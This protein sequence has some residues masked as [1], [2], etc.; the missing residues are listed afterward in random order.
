MGG[1]NGRGRNIKT[2]M[3]RFDPRSLLFLKESEIRTVCA[4]TIIKDAKT[5]TQ[6]SSRVIMTR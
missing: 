2:E 1:L 6:D 5:I 3:P 4:A